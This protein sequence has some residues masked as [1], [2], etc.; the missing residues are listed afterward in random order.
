MVNQSDVDEA[1]KLMDFSI[2]SLRTLKGSDSKGDS[3]SRMAG[4]DIQNQDR[5]TEV[6]KAVRETIQEARQNS[7]KIGE[8]VKALQKKRMITTDREELLAVL[9]HYSK[10]Q[11]IHLDQDENVIFL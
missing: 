2:R 9:T 5:M 3:K 10:L 4:R 7:L 11:I 6:I 8:I 1:I